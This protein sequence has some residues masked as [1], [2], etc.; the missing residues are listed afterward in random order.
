MVLF[1]MP[2]KVVMFVDEPR[3]YHFQ[4]KAPEQYAQGVSVKFESLDETA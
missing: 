1:I 3:Q 4:I 2:Y